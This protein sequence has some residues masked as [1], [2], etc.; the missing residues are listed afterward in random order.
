MEVININARE[1]EFTTTVKS[2]CALDNII[3]DHTVT[4]LIVGKLALDI[5]GIHGIRQ[6]RI[7]VIGAID[8]I[9]DVSL[10]CQ[11]FASETITLIT[12]LSQGTVICAGHIKKVGKVKVCGCDGRC[13]GHHDTIY[14]Y[15]EHEGEIY[16]NSAE[17]EEFV[18]IIPKEKFDIS[19]AILDAM[20]P[21]EIIKKCQKFRYPV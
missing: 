8:T 5:R 20:D 6:K 19:K 17:D 9:W 16:A 4:R 11:I 3:R 10:P 12:K 14:T 1:G 2:I 21:D 18:T 13:F 7:S 15:K